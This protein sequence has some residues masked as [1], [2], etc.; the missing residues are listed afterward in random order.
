MRVQVRITC[1]ERGE[2]WE[3]VARGVVDVL[4]H[5]SDVDDH[6]VRREPRL[7]GELMRE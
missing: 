5:Q 1:G 2:G 3:G 6:E 7:E 4:A